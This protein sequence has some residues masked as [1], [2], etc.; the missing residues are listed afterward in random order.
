M[1]YDDNEPGSKL[2]HV[3][4]TG[5]LDYE[6]ESGYQPTTISVNR[7]D[8]SY[9]VSYGKWGA[10]PAAVHFAADGQ[11]LTSLPTWRTAVAVNPTDGSLWA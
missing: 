5:T 11:V 1:D 6:G 2:Q 4:K 3:D 10:Q 7:N 9:W 8:G